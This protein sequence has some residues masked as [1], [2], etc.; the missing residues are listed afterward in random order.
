[1]TVFDFYL[2]ADL[3]TGLVTG[4]FLGGVTFLAAAAFGGVK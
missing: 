3:A 4:A 2:T 1:L